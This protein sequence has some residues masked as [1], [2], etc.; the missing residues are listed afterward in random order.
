MFVYFD[1]YSAPNGEPAVELEV[2]YSCSAANRCSVEVDRPT[3]GR[4]YHLKIEGGAW[5]LYDWRTRWVV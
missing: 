3:G 1:Y 5:H 4:V 2:R